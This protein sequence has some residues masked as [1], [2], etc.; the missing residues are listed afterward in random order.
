MSLKV[1]C[2]SWSLTSNVWRELLDLLVWHPGG[3]RCSCLPACP[4]SCK[5]ATLFSVSPKLVPEFQLSFLSNI[6]SCNSL[7]SSHEIFNRWVMSS[8]TWP[9]CYSC[10]KSF[11]LDMS[12]PLGW[13]HVGWKEGSCSFLQRS[14]TVAFV[15][16]PSSSQDSP[17]KW[18]S[19][20]LLVLLTINYFANKQKKT[21]K[22][23]WLG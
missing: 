11:I 8:F 21:F 16:T 14:R 17:K 3:H 6:P 20:S 9:F 2:W 12:R 4:S 23:M 7:K 1:C 13:P 19:H 18:H 5:E 15:H 22:Q 10:G